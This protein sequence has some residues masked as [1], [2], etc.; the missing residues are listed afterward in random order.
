VLVRLALV[1]GF[2][3]PRY[4]ELRAHNFVQVGFVFLVLPGGKLQ[5][6]LGLLNDLLLLEHFAG[7]V[8]SVLD[9]LAQI[10]PILAVFVPQ[11]HLH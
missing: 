2:A 3:Q 1:L 4:Y 6:L 11:R 10:Q 8:Y 7:E 5:E 9:R